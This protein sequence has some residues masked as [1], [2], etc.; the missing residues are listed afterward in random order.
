[1]FERENRRLIS[2]TE[3]KKLRT[4]ER[5]AFEASFLEGVAVKYY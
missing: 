2:Y 5:A 3:S 1:L 4:G